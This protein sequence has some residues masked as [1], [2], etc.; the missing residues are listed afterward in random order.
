ML[1]KECPPARSVYFW[2]YQHFY[3][4]LTFQTTGH[5][6]THFLY[7]SQAAPL[8]DTNQSQRGRFA[9]R[10]LRLRLCIICPSVC[11]GFNCNCPLS[12]RNT[13]LKYDSCGLGTTVFV[14]SIVVLGWFQDNVYQ[15][16]AH[17]Y[18]NSRRNA[19]VFSYLTLLHHVGRVQKWLIWFYAVLLWFE[20]L[21]MV[22]C[23]TK[24]VG[25]FIV[26]L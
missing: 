22:S 15:D 3:T 10:K 20:S 11:T 12:P 5:D 24:R 4:S 19:D 16:P 13:I 14:V 25:I 17:V 7:R 2:M 9:F 6:L 23:G 21:M 26:M 18:D 1:R 8:V